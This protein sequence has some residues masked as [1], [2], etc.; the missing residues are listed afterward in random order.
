MQSQLTNL[1]YGLLDRAPDE[2]GFEF[3]LENRLIPAFKA[4]FP[5]KRMILVMDNASY[6][7]QLNTKYIP[8][9][10]TPASASKGIN[11]HA[12]RKAKCK[13]IQVVRGKTV[14]KF[15]VPKQEP[16]EYKDHR[17]MG[18]HAPCSEKRGTVYAR[19]PHGPSTEEL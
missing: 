15:T 11:A 10:T 5:G 4:Q 14:H 16:A 19:Y 8:E 12:L 6:H 2:N 7:H 17:E 3:W 9:G 13:F 1:Y 18:F